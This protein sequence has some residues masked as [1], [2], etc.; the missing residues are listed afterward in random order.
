MRRFGKASLF[1]LLASFS[2]TL[3]AGCAGGGEDHAV[4]WGY[5]EHDGP[6]QWAELSPDWALCAEGQS[7]SPVDLGGAVTGG[8]FS[9]SRD[10]EPAGLRATRHEHVVDVLDNGHTVQVTYDEG[11][12]LDVDG[13]E[14]ELLQYHFHSPSEHTID[15]RHATG[16]L[17]LVHQSDTDEL[18]V[19]GVFMEI[20][21]YNRALAPIVD[22]LPSAPGETVHLEHIT[23][24]IDGLL[25]VNDRYYRYT[26]SLTTPPCWE[27]VRWFVMVEPIELSEEQVAKSNYGL[28]ANNRPTQPLHERQVVIEE[29]SGEYADR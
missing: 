27:D 21:A 4:H 16:E 20:G 13:M 26:G 5:T 8:T 25:P 6:E 28:V 10:Y 9:L 29:A 23:I 11:S 12:T 3:L 19:I 22:N 24:D 14:F 17:H 2:A 1:V 15:G 18:A 7:Q